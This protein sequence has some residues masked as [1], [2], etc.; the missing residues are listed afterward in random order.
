M[1][2][3]RSRWWSL[4]KRKWRA[5]ES[6]RTEKY[7][8]RGSHSIIFMSQQRYWLLTIPANDWTRPESLHT[9]IQYIRGQREVGG[10]TGYE[11]WQV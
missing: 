3:P 9:N 11:H 10:N 4:R 5:R 7:K 1:T 6:T 8:R 2:R